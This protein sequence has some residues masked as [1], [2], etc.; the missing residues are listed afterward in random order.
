MSKLTTVV[1][2]WGNDDFSSVI[3]SELLT[4]DASLL[5]LQNALS[6]GHYV[7]DE[8]F[9][10]MILSCSECNDNIIVKAGVFY[11]GV[12]SGCN[13]ADDPSPGNASTTEYCELQFT[14]NKLSA[15]FNVVLLAE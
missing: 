1:S 7:S 11:L 3:R 15:E 4:L 13:C 9:D 6:A 10:I 2:S 5:P 8:A 12:I 14:I